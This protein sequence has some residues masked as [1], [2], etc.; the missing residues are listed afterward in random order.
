M[1]SDYKVTENNQGNGKKLSNQS[2]LN[3]AKGDQ[4]NDQ[5]K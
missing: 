4:A 2:I 5:Y 1:Q 3:M